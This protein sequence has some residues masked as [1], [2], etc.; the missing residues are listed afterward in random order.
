MKRRPQ[1]E[2]SRRRRIEAPDQGRPER[3]GELARQLEEK[4]L[5]L[6]DTLSQF[7]GGNAVASNSFHASANTYTVRRG[8]PGADFVHVDTGRV[9]YW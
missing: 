3:A 8:D 4:H 5:P 1:A 2:H 9:R 6:L 7:Y